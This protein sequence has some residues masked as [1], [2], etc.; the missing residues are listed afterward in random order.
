M[1]QVERELL[2]VAGTV[3]LSNPGLLARYDQLDLL[4]RIA[5][6]VGARGAGGAALKGLWVLVPQTGPG[7]MPRL[8]DHPIPV[9]TKAEKARIPRSWIANVHRSGSNGAAAVAEARR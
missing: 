3:V 1:P 5:D 7:D 8:G 9:V 6:R 4:R 2:D